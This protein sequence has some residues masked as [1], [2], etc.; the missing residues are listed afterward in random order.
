MILNQMDQHI[1]KKYKVMPITKK[2]NL[3]WITNQN[4]KCK[5]I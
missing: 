3:N 2:N 4:I 1:Q 5:T